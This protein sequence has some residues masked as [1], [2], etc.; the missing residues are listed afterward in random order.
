MSVSIEPAEG[1]NWVVPPKSATDPNWRDREDLRDLIIC[2]ID[3]PGTLRAASPDRST[4]FIDVLRHRVPRYRRRP[5]RAPSCEWKHRGR[6]PY[7]RPAPMFTSA[8]DLPR[9]HRLCLALR[10]PGYADGPRSGRAWDDRVFGGQADRHAPRPPGDQSV[11]PPA[12]RGTFGVFGDLGM[13][14]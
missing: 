10:P 12:A 5:A 9:R 4:A 14:S 11:L 2:S 8:S 13:A 1:D 7:V 3:P 6:S